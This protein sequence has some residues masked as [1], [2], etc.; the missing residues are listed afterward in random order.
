MLFMLTQFTTV[1]IYKMN[2]WNSISN[3]IKSTFV[4]VQELLLLKELIK[5]YK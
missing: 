1:G 4:Q 3:I 2:D 5:L